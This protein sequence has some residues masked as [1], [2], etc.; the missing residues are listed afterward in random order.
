MGK[1]SKLTFVTNN[2]TYQFY[3]LLQKYFL[4]ITIILNTT[5]KLLLCLREQSSAH[6][7]ENVGVSLQSIVIT[8]SPLYHPGKPY[9]G[10]HCNISQ[11]MIKRCIT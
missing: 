8:K 11:I 7:F 1:F 5:G 6:M 2:Y 4:C 3:Y 10:C 9:D